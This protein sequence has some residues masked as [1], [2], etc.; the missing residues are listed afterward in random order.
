[1]RVAAGSPGHPAWT[2]A[3][4]PASSSV[5]GSRSGRYRMRA[6]NGRGGA[7]SRV[8]AA[9]R[10]CWSATRSAMDRSAEAASAYSRSSSPAACVA[11]ASPRA[12]ITARSASTDCT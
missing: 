5:R 10:A 11:S 8:T 4:P 3:L 9:P 2:G 1:M 7:P 12:S 6:E